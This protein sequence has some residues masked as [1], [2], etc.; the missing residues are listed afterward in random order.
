MRSFA[1]TSPYEDDQRP[2]YL[3]GVT[4][5]TFDNA[6]MQSRL[7]SQPVIPDTWEGVG[8]GWARSLLGGGQLPGAPAVA[9]TPLSQDNTNWGASGS[10]IPGIFNGDFQASERSVYGRYLASYAMPGWSFFNSNDPSASHQDLQGF[11]LSF[12]SINQ[13]RL[14]QVAQENNWTAEQTSMF[15]KSV[16]GFEKR[17]GEKFTLRET[18]GLLRLIDL[19][20]L[21]SGSIDL[22]QQKEATKKW[23]EETLQIPEAVS[24]FLAGKLVELFD[25]WIKQGLGGLADL[26]IGTSVDGVGDFG[27]NLQRVA[28]WGFKLNSSVGQNTK[29]DTLIHN[30]LV[31]PEGTSAL[32]Y[33][34]IFDPSKQHDD[35]DLAASLKVKIH[36]RENGQNKEHVLQNI[37]LR[38]DASRTRTIEL[39][40]F[41]TAGM[42]VRLE[43]TTD[44][45]RDVVLDDIRFG[46][47]IAVEDSDGNI[48]D[49]VVLLHDVVDQNRG[50]GELS[51]SNWS[52]AVEQPGANRQTFTLHNS[53]SK[54]VDYTVHALPPPDTSTPND[55]EN[56]LLIGVAGNPLARLTTDQRLGIPI[57][58]GV[59]G[60]NGRDEFR[61]GAE[62]TDAGR[63]ALGDRYDAAL[64]LTTLRIDAKDSSSG[65]PV[66]SDELRVFHLAELSDLDQTDGVLYA[67]AITFGQETELRF[68]NPAGLTVS[69]RDVGSKRTLWTTDTQGGITYLRLTVPDSGFDLTEEAD[70]K[71]LSGRL[72]VTLG[73]A[74]YWDGEVRARFRSPQAISADTLSLVSRIEYV[75]DIAVRPSLPVD[76]EEAAVWTLFNSVWARE[77]MDKL[78]GQ[79]FETTLLSYFGET[80]VGTT[81]ALSGL[82][83]QTAPESSESSRARYEWKLFGA[84]IESGRAPWDFDRLKFETLLLSATQDA[85]TDAVGVRA[86]EYALS[87]LLNQNQ[88]DSPEVSVSRAIYYVLSGLYANFSYPYT[89]TGAQLGAHV[90]A[91]LGWLVAHEFGHVL[92]LPDE[93]RRTGN[94]VDE[95]SNNFMGDVDELRRSEF[96]NSLLQLSLRKSRDVAFA[97]P[98][99]VSVQEMD[100]LIRH[101]MR[102][103]NS[104]TMPPAPPGFKPTLSASSV[105]SLGTGTSATDQ[106]ASSPAAGS[107]FWHG[108]PVQVALTSGE[109]T[110][111]SGWSSLGPVEVQGGQARLG[112]SAD[113][114][115]RLAQAFVLQASDRTLSFTL[116]A[117]GLVSNASGPRDA[118]EVALLDALTGAPLLGSA[119]RVSLSRSDAL[120]NL[121]S[122]GTERLAASVRKLVNADGSS[123][124]F[125]QLPEGLAGRSALLSFDLLG[126]GAL[127]SSVT[128]RDVHFVG[129]PLAAADALSLDEDGTATGDVTGNDITVGSAIASVQLVDGPLHGSL[130]LG[131]DGRYTYRPAADFFGSDGF[132]YR[133]TDAS[134]RVSNVA[135]VQIAVR[136]VNDAPTLNLSASGRSWTLGQPAV[137]LDPALTMADPEGSL[138]LATVAITGGFVAGDVLSVSGS[139]LGGLSAVYDA[140]T[141]V[142]TLSGPAPLSTYQAAMR[143][144]AFRSDSV[145]PGSVGVTRTLSWSINDGELYSAVRPFAVSVVSVN[146]PPSGADRRIAIDEDSPYALTVA[147]F[148][149]ADAGAHPFAGVRVGAVPG[150]GSLTL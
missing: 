137:T 77:W 101:L 74:T 83:P 13:D 11:N 24:D 49:G 120:L 86:K 85:P 113:R 60:P 100:D 116:A 47:P 37:N 104:D 43:F 93:Y 14:N 66:G 64:L 44:W 20:Q 147:D 48:V 80:M 59:L 72:V 102:W 103:R 10:I 121:Q 97:L 138:A 62:L 146:E 114:H 63:K 54:A 50:R 55:A 26:I 45:G 119:G 30:W 7:Q 16:N 12:L 90:G 65:A 99:G 28:N 96:Q 89:F 73:D 88:T 84:A 128:L 112:E 109:L 110:S 61:L 19:I 140:A 129:A 69:V 115:A 78:R 149:F 9:R 35:N 122:D 106:L 105:E 98:T 51:A 6:A 31:V 143:T 127:T 136:A 94:I 25:G 132:S 81:G 124:Y 53:T 23:L 8:I 38:T 71:Y 39:P 18:M 17:L 133:F 3:Q 2:W 131:A 58:Q 91:H 68:Y 111:A 1:E 141:G 67:P 117:N 125:I 76:A 36:Y 70:R 33:K 46:G 52:F 123:T 134:G 21:G 15:V 95:T 108:L 22:S 144:I 27:K 4:G 150:A 82:F 139:A 75:R 87:L 42:P 145:L 5:T 130:E 57:T 142:L 32:S 56:F 34:T 92:G 148:G 29:V 107:T 118:F 40:A 135:A 79:D 126:F 41:I